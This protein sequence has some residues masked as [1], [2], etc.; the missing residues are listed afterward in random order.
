MADF[1]T[2]EARLEWLLKQTGDP[3]V[4]RGCLAAIL[5]V[6]HRNEKLT[7]YDLDGTP[8]FAT[9]QQSKAFKKKVASDA[10]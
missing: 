7:P 8:H 3:G 6:V 10:G 2:A 4:C 5:W 1:T 9:C